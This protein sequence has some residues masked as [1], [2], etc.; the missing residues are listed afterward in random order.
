MVNDNL[1]SEFYS[2]KEGDE[3]HI[4]NYY[5]LEQVL[6]FMDLSKEDTYLV[7][8]VEAKLTEKVYENFSVQKKELW[9]ENIYSQQRISFHKE[10][11]VEALEIEDTREREEVAQPKTTK[12]EIK[13][14]RDLYVIINK[15]PI[16]LTGKIAYIF[17]DIFDFYSFDLTKA[18]GELI[19][20]VNGEKAEF[21]MELKE[22][23]VIEL[24]WKDR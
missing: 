9:N 16:K 8:N 19:T 3:I 10:T 18:R 15:E 5:T 23:D 1:V 17:V 14:T 7:N 13:A 11:D 22:R 24:Y 20:T 21:T 2:M 4:L 6:D 12:E